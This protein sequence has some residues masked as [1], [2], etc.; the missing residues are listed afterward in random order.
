MTGRFLSKGGNAPIGYKSQAWGQVVQATSKS[1]AVTLNTL[2][3]Q[4]TMNNAALAAGAEVTFTVNNNLVKANDVPNVVIKS[5]M[6]GTGYLTQVTAVAD[7]SFNITVSN[8][9]ATGGNTDALVLN[10]AI[11]RGAAA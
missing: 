7:G 11:L 9:D 2:S 8:L 1:T 4:I 5:G 10:F 3:G 6:T